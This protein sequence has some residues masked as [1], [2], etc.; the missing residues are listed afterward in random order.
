MDSSICS[1]R[2]LIGPPALIVG[3][4]VISGANYAGYS[5]SDYF[6]NDVKLESFLV[7]IDLEAH[8]I[9]PI[10][11]NIIHFKSA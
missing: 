6:C 3:A 8:S 9:D 1:P 4:V 10:L 11:T 2:L 5:K 7:P